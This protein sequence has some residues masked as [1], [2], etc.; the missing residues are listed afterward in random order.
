M[1]TFIMKLNKLALFSLLSLTAAFSANNA[2]ATIVTYTD[3]AT[4]LSLLQP[5]YFEDAF[6]GVTNGG[7]LLRRP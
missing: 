7:L 6:N 2:H 5:G 3:K 1:D 4:F